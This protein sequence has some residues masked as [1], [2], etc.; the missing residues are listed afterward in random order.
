MKTI[1][2][3]ETNKSGSSREAIKAAER[4]GYLTVL[5]T[6]N[7]RFLEQRVQFHDVHVMIYSELT[8]EDL[9]ETLLKLEYQ[10]KEI[11]GILSFI[12]SYVCVA[13]GLAD[14]WGIS[15]FSTEAIRKMESKIETHNVLGESIS[16]KYDVFY[17]DDTLP[18]FLNRLKEGKW[19]VKPSNSTGSKDVA[20]TS[21]HI[22][23]RQA[24]EHLKDKLPNEPILVEEY[25]DGPQYLVEALVDSG[26]VH[27]IAVI[28]QSFS[29]YNPFVV[30][31]YS[32][33]TD[34]EEAF[35]DHL[36]QYVTDTIQAFDMKRGA[37]HLE[38]RFVRGEWRL[39]EI[40]P[41]IS[42]GAMNAMIEKAYGINL[43]EQTI[44]LFLGQTIE[45]SRQWEQNIH[46]HYVTINS[47]GTL[48]KVTGRKSAE[49]SEGVEQVFVKPKKGMMLSPPVSMGKRYAYVIANGDTL[50][51]AKM[52]AQSAAEKLYFHLEEDEHDNNRHAITS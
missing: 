15:S 7:N 49:K 25:L 43:A 20:L 32:I 48:L 8:N 12:E 40:N 17:P 11:V 52:N 24:L 38:M 31:G 21:N 3:I 2:F 44:R 26:D 9:T 6:N 47:S 35:Y 37:C 19:I 30:A 46:T 29:E 27:I 28:K 33:Q 50:K 10:G 1:V 45:L 51:E 39:I 14:K 22:E 36:Y 13:S 42:G 23:L 41:R 34:L 18:M 16:S 4:M 5:L